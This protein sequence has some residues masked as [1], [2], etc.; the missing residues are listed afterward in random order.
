[1][2]EVAHPKYPESKA[3]CAREFQSVFA[4]DGPGDESGSDDGVKELA[5]ACKACRFRISL[6]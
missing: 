1:V 2:A 3:R 6:P 4:R 5:G